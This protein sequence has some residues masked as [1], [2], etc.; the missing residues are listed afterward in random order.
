MRRRELLELAAGFA[1]ASLQTGRG[2]DGNASPARFTSQN[3][4]LD[5]VLE[6]YIFFRQVLGRR[7]KLLN[8]NGLI[9]GPILEARPGDVV[10]LLVRNSLDHVTNLHFHGLHVTPGG[11]GDNVLL[12]IER[13]QSFLYLFQIP[14][15]HPAGL[16]WFH[17]HIHGLSGAQVRSGLAGVFSIRGDF[18]GIGD[19]PEA[20]EYDIV[21][22]TLDY[23]V[24]DELHSAEAHV[25][26]PPPAD[27]PPSL[28]MINGV[29]QL[30][31]QANVTRTLNVLQGGLLRL[32]ILNASANRIIRLGLRTP[33]P[34]RQHLS[35]LIA[36]DGHPVAQPVR[37][38]E[39]VMAPGQRAELLVKTDQ[40]EGRFHLMELPY[41]PIADFI[42]PSAPIARVTFE[43]SGT[44]PRE[45]QI[46][47]KLQDVEPR[48]PGAKHPVH[49]G[50]GAQ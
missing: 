50:P 41:S 7:Y 45:L 25:H 47:D 38:D 22:Q 27:E 21:Y 16:Y 10:R 35:Y 34:G 40:R 43:Y 12:R 24:L 19:L 32:R 33:A 17:P 20:T 9:P 11:S 6:P 15:Y 13:D 14:S 29:P 3:G 8:Y 2:Q 48:P 5:A 37:I 44:A 42:Q 31:S 26:H 30:D 39:L 49:A 18:D 46:P 1:A 36:T 28:V 23:F 4:I